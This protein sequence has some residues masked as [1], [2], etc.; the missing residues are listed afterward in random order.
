M[1][2]GAPQL[3]FDYAK[4]FQVFRDIT[5]ATNERTLVVDNI[6]TTAVGNNAPVINY[7]CGR[8]VASALVLANMNSLPFDWAARLS[9][10]GTHMSFFIVK[11]LPVL[12]P[13][14]YLESACRDLLW[15]E[16]I[17]PRAVELTYTDKDLESFA[18]DIGYQGPPFPWNEK[19]R[20]ALQC[21]LDAVFFHMYRLDRSEVEWILDAPPPSSSFPRVK[22]NE[23]KKFGEYRT[24]RYVLSAYDQLARNQNPNLKFQQ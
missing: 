16:L 24:K 9:V 11:Q 5:N 20:H 2:E 12:P 22:N 3:R 19:R 7:Q 23:I 4:S 18:R 13:E 6:P 10:G 8:M 15:V 1:N 21:E 17:I 14:S